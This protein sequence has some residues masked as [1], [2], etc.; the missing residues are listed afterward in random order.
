[1]E[2]GFE[3]TPR[4]LGRAGQSGIEAVPCFTLGAVVG[5]CS[6]RCDGASWSNAKHGSAAASLIGVLRARLSLDN[7]SGQE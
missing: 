7:D 6:V 1:M 4:Q 5:R 2:M 3:S